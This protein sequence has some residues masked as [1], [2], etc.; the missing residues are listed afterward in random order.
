LTLAIGGEKGE[1]FSQGQI[2]IVRYR[3]NGEELFS[4]ERGD[5]RALAKSF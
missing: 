5:D 2:E 1:W 4:I 3:A